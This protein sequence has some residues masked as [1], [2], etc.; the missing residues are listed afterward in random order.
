MQTPATCCSGRHNPLLRIPSDRCA[1]SIHECIGYYKCIIHLA[2]ITKGTLVFTAG[3]CTDMMPSSWVK[4]LMLQNI[5]L[6]SCLFV[7]FNLV[8]DA[9]GPV[10]WKSQLKSAFLYETAP[11]SSITSSE[12]ERIWLALFRSCLYRRSSLRLLWCSGLHLTCGTFMIP[13]EACG[14]SSIK[15]NDDQIEIDYLIL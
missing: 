6:F 4:W 9:K 5:W 10:A 13:R 8:T 15:G 7:F 12:K 2:L 14:K 1:H 11:I 3:V